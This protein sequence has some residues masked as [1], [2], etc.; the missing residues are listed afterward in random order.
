MAG[1]LEEEQGWQSNQAVYRNVNVAIIYVKIVRPSFTRHPQSFIN[2]S[3]IIYLL[4]KAA[5]IEHRVNVE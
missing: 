2:P 4:K 5:V 1:R 3:G